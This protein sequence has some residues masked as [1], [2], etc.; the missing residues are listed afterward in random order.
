MRRRECRRLL[1]FALSTFPSDSGSAEEGRLTTP[2]PPIPSDVEAWRGERT[3]TPRLENT[4]YIPLRPTTPPCWGRRRRILVCSAPSPEPQ[5]TGPESLVWGT[6]KT[7]RINHKAHTCHEALLG[8]HDKICF[9]LSLAARLGLRWGRRRIVG[10]TRM[11]SRSGRWAMVGRP[12]MSLGLGG[13]PL[14]SGEQT[15]GTWG[16][17]HDD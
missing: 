17:K 1:T 7:G 11:T 12:T 5:T 16:I 14:G 4:Q 2:L 10:S 8:N 9:Q 13:S 6:Q 15:I 3:T